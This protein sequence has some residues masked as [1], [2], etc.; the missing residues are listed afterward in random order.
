MYVIA[1]EKAVELF[2]IDHSA[3]YIS[4]LFPIKNKDAILI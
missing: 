4:H 1:W 3:T 2:V